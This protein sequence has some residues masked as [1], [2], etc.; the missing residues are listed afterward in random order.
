ME[1]QGF[2]KISTSQ[3]THILEKKTY[4]GKKRPGPISERLS[5]KIEHHPFSRWKN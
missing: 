3:T 1:K 2:E 4:Q 5:C